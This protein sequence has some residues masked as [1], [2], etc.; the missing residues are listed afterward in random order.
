M[1]VIATFN[2]DNAAFEDNLS[3]ELDFIAKQIAHKAF[4]QILIDNKCI[5]INILLDSNGNSVGTIY[6]EK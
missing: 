1:K 4:N 2:C 6:V 5:C 3:T